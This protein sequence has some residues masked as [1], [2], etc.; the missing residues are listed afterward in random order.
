MTIFNQEL[1]DGTIVK[2]RCVYQ[3]E[4]GCDVL[5]TTIEEYNAHAIVED[6]ADD[7]MFYCY[8]DEAEFMS[9]D[10]AEFEDYVN[11]NYN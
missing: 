4:L 3:R 8:P 9:M 6:S 2:C 1:S 10:D 5:V 7:R 11:E